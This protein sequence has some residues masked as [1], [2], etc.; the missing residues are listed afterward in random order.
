MNT[1]YYGGE[2]DQR[3]ADVRA[4]ERAKVK[5]IVGDEL[6]IQGDAYEFLFNKAKADIRATTLKELGEYMSGLIKT[7]HLNR[8]TVEELII[9]ALQKGKM[10][11]GGE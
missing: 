10:P 2:I 9:E 6:A 8:L 3:I 5:E 4:E 1:K 11:D 7:G